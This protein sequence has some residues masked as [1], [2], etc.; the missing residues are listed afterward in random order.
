MR[1]TP[2]AGHRPR[3]FP[4]LAEPGS[5]L[6]V[7]GV[8]SLL[9]SVNTSD[10]SA[11]FPFAHVPDIIGGSISSDLGHVHGPANRL[12]QPDMAVPAQELAG[13]INDHVRHAGGSSRRQLVRRHRATFRVHKLGKHRIGRRREPVTAA[14]LS[15]YENA[16]P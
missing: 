11:S 12:F 9:T 10:I 7:D 5:T 13:S 4:T 6:L 15:P 3:Y 1:I 16:N 14:I 8:T 2:Y